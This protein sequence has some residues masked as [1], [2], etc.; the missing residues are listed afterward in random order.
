MGMLT[1]LSGHGRYIIQKWYVAEALPQGHQERPG[2][3][4]E[5][6]TVAGQSHVL[7]DASGSCRQYVPFLADDDSMQVDRTRGSRILAASSKPL[8]SLLQ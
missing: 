3:S 5:S 8:T 4:M 7:C 2:D 1:P 6:Y